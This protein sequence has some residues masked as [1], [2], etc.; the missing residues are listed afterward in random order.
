LLLYDDLKRPTNR[1]HAL[2]V[3][4]QMCAALRFYSQGAFYR[5]T[6]DC[7]GISKSSQSRCVYY[8]SSALIRRI[9]L[10]IKFSKDN[11]HITKTK[12]QFYQLSSFPNVLGAID[13]THINIIAPV[14]IKESDYINR[15]NCLSI[16]VQAVCDSKQMF[17]NVVVKYHGRVHDSFIWNNCS[18]KQYFEANEVNGWLLGDSGYPQE[19]HLMTP[20][21]NPNSPS[22]ERY[23]RSHKKSRQIIEKSFGIL[24]N[25]FRCLDKSAGNLLLAPERACK[26]ITS[27]FILHNFAKMHKLA[28]PEMDITEN[29]ES[30][31]HEYHINI[32]ASISGQNARRN[33]VNIAFT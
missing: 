18:L 23:N 30:N 24:K 2:P 31:E 32:N 29:S 6:G 16:K 19:I 8:V 20:F 4:I 17:S 13:G 5:V 3:V 25:R 27:C 10:F 9:N 15:K 14:G 12:E 21:I 22:E 11:E 33:L 28:D 7:L 1:N 26:V